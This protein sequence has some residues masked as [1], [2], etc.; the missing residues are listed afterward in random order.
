MPSRSLKMSLKWRLIVLSVAL[1]DM[2]TVGL[3]V[4]GSCDVSADGCQLAAYSQTLSGSSRYFA[5]VA[6]RP[7]PFDS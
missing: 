1:G 6:V 3:T 7:T 2:P 5:V 4:F